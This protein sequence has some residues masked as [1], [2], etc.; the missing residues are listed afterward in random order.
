M[1]AFH[2][3]KR[4]IPNHPKSRGATYGALW[5]TTWYNPDCC[6]YILYVLSRPLYS[7]PNIQ[8]YI[9]LTTVFCKMQYIFTNIV[10]IV[11]EQP[12]CPA[13]ESYL[14]FLLGRISSDR[15]FSRVMIS[16]AA[17]QTGNYLRMVFGLYSHTI[18]IW[19]I[20]VMGMKQE[21]SCIFRI[22]TVNAFSSILITVMRP[23]CSYVSDYPTI[24]YSSLKTWED[25]AALWWFNHSIVCRE[26][27]LGNLA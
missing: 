21:F 25:P 13:M 16:L 27:F 24:K 3:A 5:Y 22:H 1:L 9:M 6:I 12:Q 19:L 17:C 4:V 23:L 10:S 15:S 8:H 18:K 26:I 7:I 11:A 2:T 20:L 14:T